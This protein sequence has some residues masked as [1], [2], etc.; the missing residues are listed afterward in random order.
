[1]GVKRVVGVGVRHVWCF[2]VGRGRLAGLL[3]GLKV[4]CGGGS[5]A[6]CMRVRF[7]KPHRSEC[8]VL[9]RLSAVL[10]DRMDLPGRVNMAQEACTRQI[11][12]KYM[13]PCST[14]YASTDKG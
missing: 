5:C 8:G 10:H 6:A 14:Q 7:W 9:Y 12:V 4:G 3:V 13:Y 2:G 11:L 1:M